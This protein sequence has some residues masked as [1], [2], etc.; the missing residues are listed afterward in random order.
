[1]RMIPKGK[2][3]SVEFIKK[4]GSNR[5]MN[6]RVGVRKGVK[7]IGLKYNPIDKGL[8]TVYDMNKRDFRTI[9]AKTIKSLTIEGTKFEV[10]KL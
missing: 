5:T 7:G 3:F 6:C 1:M 2:I 9:N 8:L 4:D 10:N